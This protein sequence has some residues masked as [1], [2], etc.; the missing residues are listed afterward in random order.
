M[1]LSQGRALIDGASSWKKGKTYHKVVQTYSR[2]KFKGES[3]DW[4]C[5]VSVHGSEEG[6]FDELWEQ[7]GPDKGEKEVR[8]ACQ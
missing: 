6:T 2:P 8:Y 7:L 5:R 3:A 1:L 4:H